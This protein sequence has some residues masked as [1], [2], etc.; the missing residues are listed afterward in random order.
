M[1][2]SKLASLCQKIVKF[3]QKKL[4]IFININVQENKLSRKKTL[5]P[6]HI[7]KK[8][9]LNLISCDISL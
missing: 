9:Y 7:E 6:K 4:L 3:H 1:H 8:P 2:N 5:N